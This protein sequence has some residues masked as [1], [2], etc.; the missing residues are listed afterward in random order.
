MG[1]GSR[2]P[3]KNM[4][5]VAMKLFLA[6]M[7]GRQNLLILPPKLESLSRLAIVLIHANMRLIRYENAPTI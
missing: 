1:A 4:S 3:I 7:I 2:E 5:M 6:L